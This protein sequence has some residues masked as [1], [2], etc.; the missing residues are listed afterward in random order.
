MSQRR[1]RLSSP[2]RSVDGSITPLGYVLEWTPHSHHRHRLDIVANLRSELLGGEP[3]G[4]E[5]LIVLRGDLAPDVSDAL[6]SLA[7]IDGG[8]LDAHVQGKP[9]RPRGR[10]KGARWWTWRYPEA[11]SL[12]S[13][14]QQQQQVRSAALWLSSPIPVLIVDTPLGVK[15]GGNGGVGERWCDKP[16]PRLQHQD[17][18]T[19]RSG[20]Q[21]GGRY[22]GV[23]ARYHAS[24]PPSPQAEKCKPAAAAAVPAIM[25][26]DDELASAMDHVEDVVLEE[27][28]AELV[29]ER[30]TASLSTLQLGGGG[31]AARLLWRYMVALERN[32]DDSRYCAR[33]GRFVEHASPAAWTDLSQRAQLRIQLTSSSRHQQQ[34]QRQ[35][36]LRHRDDTSQEINGSTANERSL[37]RIAYLGGMLLPVS[38]VASILAIEGRYGPE[39]AQFW[40]FWA[41]SVAASA[42]ALLVIYLDRLRLAEVW[43]EMPGGGRAEEAVGAAG[44]G[45]VDG[46][47]KVIAAAAR[48]W[49][50]EQ[51][52]W[53]RALKQ[54]TGYYR[55]RGARW[56][57]F[58]SPA[59]REEDRRDNVIIL[60]E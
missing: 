8:F 12:S 54:A 58:Q 45:V 17:A 18:A 6:R 59:K 55:L 28:L 47:T 48:A 1:R 19:R 51:L 43:V 21:G 27:M 9:F 40:V 38:V 31:D 3:P 35:Q 57:R 26:L 53:A 29:Y 52:G 41:A 36:Q 5:Q 20:L 46:G 10:A 50:R 7:G 11:S 14:Q 16:A 44:L 37:D 22:G 34:Q 23:M 2:P 56:I 33:Q 15:G 60:E 32:L 49:H 4:V 25:A 13:S 39:G 30:W 24:P 42:A